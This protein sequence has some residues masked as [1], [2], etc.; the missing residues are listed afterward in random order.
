MSPK[1]I[2]LHSAGG[3]AGGAPPNLA[4]AALELYKAEPAGGGGKPGSAIGRIPF[5]FN[6]KEL[7]IQKSAKWERKPAKGA[8]AAGPPEF[9]G[10][11]P[12][13]LTLEIFFDATD[14][15]DSS[16]VDRVEQLFSCCVPTDESLDKKKASPPLVVL[17]WGKVT[18]FA[19]FVT[20]VQAKY[21]LFTPDGTPIRATCSVA[22]EEM[23]GDPLK[24]NPTSG[25][26]ATRSMHTLMAGDSLASIAY[27]EY[28]DPALWRL[29]AGFNEID[30]PL[31]L[32]IGSPLLI[33][34]LEELLAPVA[35]GR[36]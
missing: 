12:C 28:G 13:K 3:K 34:A 26:L 8:K 20:S 6:P 23:P 19:A 21:T 35:D 2:A 24:Q 5:Q 25:A 27:R 1:A 16:V 22:L 15:M 32:R 4:R 11:D 17:H 7:S 30:D 29:L 36:W 33:P 9:T 10:A 14:S 31:R 18:S